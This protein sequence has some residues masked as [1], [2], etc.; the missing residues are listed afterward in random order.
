M[1][2]ATIVRWGRS[3][4][5]SVVLALAAAGSVGPAEPV[6]GA[7]PVP[8]S[9][10][11]NRPEHRSAPHVVLISLD[12][13]RADYLDRFEL[14][15]L[16][17]LMRRGT[18]ARSMVPVFPTLTFP[19]HY[20]LVTG[21]YPER[22]GIVAN[23]FYDPSRRAQYGMGDRRAVGDATWYRGEPIWV[24][25]ER[26][27]MVAACF[28][29]PGSEAAINGVRPTFY[30]P[31]DAQIPNDARVS[32]VLEWLR[33]PDDRRPHLITLYFSQLDTV[34]HRT[35]LNSSEVRRAA[36]SLDHSL[37][38]LFDGL[39]GLS[40]KERVYVIVTSDHGMVETSRAETIRLDTL[41]DVTRLEASFG[42][43]VASL[44]VGGGPARAG[45][46]RD[47]I[48]AQ[49]KHG[50]AYLRAEVPERF[51]Y[52][53]DPRIGDVVVVMDEPWTLVVPG[54]QDRER[55]PRWGTHG[56]PPELASMRAVFVIAGPGVR[57][58]ATID[59]VST[60][61]VYPLMSELLGLDAA[62]AV[63]GAAGTLRRM[64][65]N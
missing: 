17:R 58:G 48:N 5:L 16:Q 10:G 41:I 64:V 65:M 46:I 40:V 31:Y 49:L 23:S 61:D 3:L 51:H 56:W 26:Q 22:H 20:S 57:A 42:G 54:V 60:I 9:G 12:G 44:H 32:T 43:P 29:W 38:A 21:L 30:R 35:S 28:F 50:L 55:A 45:Q 59:D 1:L 2:A 15:N 18:R 33:L 36:Q 25:A 52:R 19:N 4:V 34:S 27:G 62:P 11:I 8:G 13:F 24:T 7:R 47:Q 39:E 53:A 6:E 14:P 63:D 37:G